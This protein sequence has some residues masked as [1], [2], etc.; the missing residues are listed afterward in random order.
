MSNIDLLNIS[1]KLTGFS[2]LDNSDLDLTWGY[3]N[4]LVSCKELLI[5][6]LSK[7]YSIPM[8]DYMAFTDNTNSKKVYEDFGL[9]LE[10][11]TN[12]Q[13]LNLEL[14]NIQKI[15]ECFCLQTFSFVSYSSDILYE[16][17]D[18]IPQDVNID[19]IQKFINTIE[20]F[21]NSQDGGDLNN[22]II[23]VI[24]KIFLLMSIFIPITSSN[25]QI[26]SALQ[27]ITNVNNPYQPY[28]TALISVQD[29][30]F[31]TTIKQ[32]KTSIPQAEEFDVSKTLITYDNEVQQSLKTI[33]GQLISLFSTPENGIKV[34]N[35]IV[36]DFNKKSNIF[37]QEASKSCFE[38]I[39]IIYDRG[40]FS[41][42]QDLDSIEQTNEKIN[43]IEKIV[44][45]EKRN[46]MEKAGVSAMAA[47][48]SAASYV[49]NPTLAAANMA[50][51]LVS[52]GESVTDLIS[53]T[54]KTQK[55]IMEVATTDQQQKLTAQEKIN[56]ESNLRK[57]SKLYCSYGYNLQLNFDQNEKTLKVIGS[58]INYSWME[59]L[60]NVL[61]KNL[62]LEITKLSTNLEEN[63]IQLQ[64]IISTK[65]RLNIL[66]RIT[67]YL[68]E[69][70]NFSSDSK[71]I[72]LQVYPSKDTPEQI[73]LYFDSELDELN[74]LL[75]YLQMQFPQQKKELE[76]NKKIIEEQQ[77]LAI[78]K[79]E[80]ININT[81]ATAI[82]NQMAAERSARN[83]ASQFYAFKTWAQS[84]VE[85]AKNGTR[86]GFQSTEE[87][88]TE[89]SKGLVNIVTKP[90]LDAIKEFFLLLITNPSGWIVLG[91]GLIAFLIIIELS[92]LGLIKTFVSNGYKFVVFIFGN[93]I[94]IFKVIVTPFGWLLKKE[95]VLYI[96]PSTDINTNIDV[97]QPMILENNNNDEIQAAQALLDLSRSS[98]GGK[99]TKKNKKQN[100]NKPKKSKKHIKKINKNKTKKN[101]KLK[102]NNRK[103]SRR[104]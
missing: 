95:K 83:V 73:K 56:L 50:S 103:K 68:A 66:K 78:Q 76:N 80:I 79:Q 27:L 1:N 40:L 38:L 4:N 99:K 6:M 11:A 74:K 101:K 67:I 88:L 32:I 42:I 94:Y 3:L 2:N 69:I 54:S 75:N 63:N 43:Q 16:L 15:L 97:P 25:E 41:N 49:T 31:K 28:N 46:T 48:A 7:I 96:Q 52:F 5:L 57:Y 60:I 86:F 14:L 10:Q 8:I 18:N 34:F 91:T 9:T 89:I 19:S 87:V 58:K 35:D 55:Q 92:G 81:N 90:T 65:Q 59:N 30:E 26:L 72:N 20:S 71:M 44:E 17:I 61:E 33:T 13:S 24:I 21:K 70:I 12:V 84:Y 98:R 23:V 93:I 102:K 77:E 62:E 85:M 22:K 51:Y 64:L 36:V 47:V 39:D 53:S 104:N 29:D 82:I 45:E 37:T 100:K